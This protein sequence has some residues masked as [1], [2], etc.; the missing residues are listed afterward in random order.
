MQASEQSHKEKFFSRSDKVDI[1]YA[2]IAILS[3]G[4]LVLCKLVINFLKIGFQKTSLNVV[5]PVLKQLEI[6]KI[7]RKI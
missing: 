1:L 7:T 6:K 5:I 2:L 3:Q 4:K